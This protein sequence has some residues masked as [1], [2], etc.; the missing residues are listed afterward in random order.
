MDLSKRIKRHITA[1][2][3]AFRVVCHPGFERTCEA[4]MRL[5]GFSAPVEIS[6]GALDFT[7]RVEEAWKILA[8]SRTCT[9]IVMRI[10]SF[11]AENFG[12]FEKK[13]ES[14]PWELFLPR[15][16]ALQV[17]V[18]SKKSR[19]YHTDA[20]AERLSRI[21]KNTVGC[22]YSPSAEQNLFVHIENDRC[23]FSVDLAGV[24]LYKR[25]F[26]RHVEAAPLRDTL[27]AAILLEAGLLHTNELLDPMAGSGTFSSE[28]ALLLARAHLWKTRTFALQG[29]PFFR[30]AAWNFLASHTPGLSV[31]ENLKISAG[32]I[33]EKAFGTL[34]YNLRTNGARP[35]LKDLPADALKISRSDFFE[36]PKAKDSSLVVLNPPFGKRI[37]AN[38]PELY[39]EIGKKIRA[40]FGRSNVAVIAPTA[41]AEKALALSP[42]KR[43]ET[44]HGGLSVR[45][46]FL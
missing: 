4:E 12:R 20:V 6:R 38:V 43:I 21:L 26:E 23:T 9:R 11:N 13:A 2:P 28:A 27:A 25:G 18:S 35:F 1:I 44:V 42:K 8:F 32:D 40:D 24:P 41:E 10:E 39:R 22:K 31:S 37:R 3:H 46:L 33:S 29:L 45:V 30:P 19:L 7:A 15:N 17:R 16:A 36:L 5:L 14:V 34:E